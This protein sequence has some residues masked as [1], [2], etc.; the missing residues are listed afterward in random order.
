LALPTGIATGT[1]TDCIAVASPPNALDYA[2]LHTESGEAI[3]HAVFDAT[4]EGGR[5]WMR[6]MKR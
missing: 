4:F 2:G 1:G 5:D 6:D 3:G